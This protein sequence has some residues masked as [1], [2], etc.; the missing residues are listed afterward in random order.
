LIEAG[1]YAEEWSFP[2][3]S[4]SGQTNGTCNAFGTY[5]PIKAGIKGYTTLQANN[6]SQ[7]MAAVATIGPLAINVDA[8]VWHNYESGIWDGCS[9]GKDILCMSVSGG[10]ASFVLNCF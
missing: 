3:V 1:G 2:Y 5:N 4:F 9:Y 10:C 6:A 8:S 7:V